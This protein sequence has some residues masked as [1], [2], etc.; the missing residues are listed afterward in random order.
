MTDRIE[1]WGSLY[2][3]CCCKQEKV[4]VASIENIDIPRLMD[5]ASK[6]QAY[7]C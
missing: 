1:T 4:L 6:K 3:I 7:L 5:P 2:L